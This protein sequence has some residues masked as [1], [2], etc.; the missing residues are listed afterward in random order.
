MAGLLDDCRSSRSKE[1]SADRTSAECAALYRWGG[2]P[3]GIW[4]HSSAVKDTNWRPSMTDYAPCHRHVQVCVYA[5]RGRCCRPTVLRRNLRRRELLEQFASARLSPPGSGWCQ[6]NARPRASSVWAASAGPA[7]SG[8]GSRCRVA[9]SKVTLPFGSGSRNPSG[10][11]AACRNTQ[12]GHTTATAPHQNSL[13][14][15][16]APRGTSTRALPLLANYA[17]GL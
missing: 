3:R 4:C 17:A 2:R 14:S 8:C 1:S 12:A 15:P 11:A 7:M 5:A 9:A 6:A 10:P 13:A 16:L